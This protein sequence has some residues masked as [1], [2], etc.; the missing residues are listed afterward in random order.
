MDIGT[1]LPS[2]AILLSPLLAEY[3]SALH[4]S[5]VSVYPFHI[6]R[7]ALCN[8]AHVP[9][10]PGQSLKGGTSRTRLQQLYSEGDPP[11]AIGGRISMSRC[12]QGPSS[13]GVVQA[14][15]EDNV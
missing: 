14:I 3:S 1:L 6:G 7:Q 11:D 8:P 2:Q 15:A 13:P 5:V 4:V 9:F 10:R 12:W